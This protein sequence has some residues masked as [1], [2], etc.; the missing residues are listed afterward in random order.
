MVLGWEQTVSV[1]PAGGFGVARNT[2]PSDFY[3]CF[4]HIGDVRKEP[5]IIMDLASSN[6]GE[7]TPS[8][9]TFL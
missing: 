6:H 3:V 2:R 4:A 9:S 7:G 8:H 5:F 1:P